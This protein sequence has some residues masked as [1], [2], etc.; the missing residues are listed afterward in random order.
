M[1]VRVETGIEKRIPRAHVTRR[2]LQALGRIA[3]QPARARVT[4][5]D[6]NGPKGGA[7]VRCSVVVTLPGKAPISITRVAPTARAA[8]DAA[9]E[10]AAR[11][12]ERER[13]R[14]LDARRHPKKYYAARRLLG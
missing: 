11:L 1:D 7:D 6:D 3:A 2:L 10:R 9:Y 13:A 12:I 14:W 4:F 8:F 5:T